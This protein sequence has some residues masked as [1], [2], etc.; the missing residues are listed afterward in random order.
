[1]RRSCWQNWA[2]SAWYV[3]GRFRPS[4]NCFTAIGLGKG[5]TARAGNRQTLEGAT[6]MSAKLTTIIERLS[7]DAKF[8]EQLQSNPDAALKGYDL[9]TEERAALISGD[10][11][12]LESLGVDAR[13]S[14]LDS[15]W[16]EQQ[17]GPFATDTAG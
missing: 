4:V 3:A 11:G 15:S 5:Y 8:R 2:G 16:F 1:M 12:R 14:K 10:V 6:T 9:T 13:V 17:Q 7:T